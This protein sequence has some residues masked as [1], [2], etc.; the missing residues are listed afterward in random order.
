MSGR[1]EWCVNHNGIKGTLRLPANTNNG[2]K[3]TERERERPNS[4]H[5]SLSSES[6]SL[7]LRSCSI[8]RRFADCTTAPWLVADAAF[9]DTEECFPFAGSALPFFI[10]E[11]CV[12]AGAEQSDRLLRLLELLPLDSDSSSLELSLL[13][14]LAV[15]IREW[16]A[17]TGAVFGL[18]GVPGFVLLSSLSLPLLLLLNVRPVLPSLDRTI[19]ACWQRLD[20]FDPWVGRLL[21]PMLVS[22]T[23]VF[24]FFVGDEVVCL[25]R[26]ASDWAELELPGVWAGLLGG[27]SSVS[28]AGFRSSRVFF[29][30]TAL[31][32]RS[33]VSSPVCQRLY[34]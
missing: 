9:C 33:S 12:A 19:R 32:I 15:S 23:P 1:E 25:D 21:A 34:K 2:N 17:G 7:N 28:A 10:G 14:F 3:G 16:C 27:A 6:L 11:A 20:S 26:V 8:S 4:G 29:S 30:C 13:R 22:V 31:A 24:V 18:P 5:S